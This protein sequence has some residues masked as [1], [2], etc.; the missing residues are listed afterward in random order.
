MKTKL[1]AILFVLLAA[2][3][4]LLTGQ[5]RDIS[6]IISSAEKPSIA[7]ID[8]RGAGEAQRVMDPFNQ[9]LW[10]ELSGSGVLKMVSKSLYPL[11]V[12]QQPQDFHPPSGG[13]SNSP[14]LTDWSNPPVSTNYLAFGYTA[15]QN[16]QLVLRR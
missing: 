5:Q 14:W 7:V 10:D 16:N 9:T 1:L 12:P 13:R 2:A 15:T 8:F 4:L 11:N 3:A 6:G